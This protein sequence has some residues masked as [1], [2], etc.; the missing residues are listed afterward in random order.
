MLDL[1]SGYLEVRLTS[2]EASSGTHVS[3]MVDERTRNAELD[4]NWM[5][6]LRVMQL[7]ERPMPSSMNWKGTR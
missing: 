3:D 5:S 7:R 4:W 2:G 1:L 6:S